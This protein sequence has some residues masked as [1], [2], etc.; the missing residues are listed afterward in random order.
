MIHTCCVGE[1]GEE[2]KKNTT[3][4]LLETN[5]T[6]FQ[7]YI[8]RDS[9]HDKYTLEND[10]GGAG[11]GGGGAI[12]KTGNLGYTRRRKTKQKQNTICVGHHY[13]YANKHKLR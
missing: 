13:V 4:C 8:N 11:G 2:I 12:K 9:T 3:L 5:Q 7:F 1:H 6:T 10:E